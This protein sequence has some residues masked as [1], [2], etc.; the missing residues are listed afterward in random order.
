MLIF[1]SNRKYSDKLEDIYLNRSKISRVDE[2][3]YLGLLIDSNLTWNSHVNHVL[4]KLGPYVGIFRKISFV[5]SENVKK[6][7]YHSFFYSNITYLLS[8]WGG[9]NKNNIKKIS[10]MQNKCIRNLF[11]NDYKVGKVSTNE[12]YKKHNILKFENVI[13]LELNINLYKIVNKK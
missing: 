4:K 3:K 6:M 5:C 7:L 13:E 1:N 11:F 12:L 10:T 2:F 9:T 8:V